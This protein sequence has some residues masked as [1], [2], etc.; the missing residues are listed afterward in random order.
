MEKLVHLL[1]YV[2]FLT[3][4]F[5]CAAI[6]AIP[7]FTCLF[8]WTSSVHWFSCGRCMFRFCNKVI[9]KAIFK[10][11]ITI[12]SRNFLF[13]NFFLI[14]SVWAFCSIVHDNEFSTRLSVGSILRL[15]AAA[16]TALSENTK[17]DTALIFRLAHQFL[18]AN[19]SHS[20]N[21]E[22]EDPAKYSSGTSTGEVLEWW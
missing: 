18:Y 21:I 4:C 9:L 22:A 16:L 20:I 17:T 8:L 13:F 12:L 2:Q 11:K 3:F 1:F 7:K 14:V 5:L 19:N 15:R 10:G 6:S